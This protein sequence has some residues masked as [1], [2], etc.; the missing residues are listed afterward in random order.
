LI[1][2][3]EDWETHIH[4][5]DNDNQGLDF[6]QTIRNLRRV[7][8]NA[9]ADTTNDVSNFSA[10]RSTLEQVEIT[11]GAIDLPAGFIFECQPYDGFN[12]YRFA[13][14]LRAIPSEKTALFKYRIGQ[15][16]AQQVAIAEE[17]KQSI[18]NRVSVQDIKIYLGEMAYQ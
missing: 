5:F 8:V 6:K 12:D 18:K 16:E 3:F 15:L 2:F 1:D 4:F 13:C 10:A 11:A 9:K 14:Q 17:F 7:K